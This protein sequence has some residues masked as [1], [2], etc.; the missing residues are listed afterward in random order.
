MKKYNPSPSGLP[1]LFVILYYL[2][3]IILAN[4]R[5]RTGGVLRLIVLKIIGFLLKILVW[6]LLILLLLV[7]VAL[8][9]PLHLHVKYEPEVTLRLRYFFLKFYIL[10]EK[11]PKKPPG[12]FRRALA[13]VGKFL[14]TVLSLIKAGI[15]ALFRWIGKGFRWVKAKLRR[16]PKKKKTVPKKEPEEKRLSFFGALKEQRGFFGA[17]E[18][19]ADAGKALGGAVGKIYR[20]I[21]ID[22]L[23]LHAAISGEDAADTAV[24]Y[25]R[26]CA[27][28]FPALSFLLGS[29]RGYDPASPRTKDIEIV[30]DFAGEGI[31]L[32][33]IGEFTLF[34]LL[35]VGNLLWAVIQFAVSQ[36]KI[37][38][39]IKKERSE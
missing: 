31:K 15:S 9:I 37:S 13:A 36:L 28:V 25:G 16:K 19:F 8:C 29:T 18:F 22:R 6:L 38:S 14:L 10:G 21:R 34:P 27:G 12:L 35:M 39:K 33:F 30:P 2:F 26:I 20:G 5:E 11:P 4:E 3:S 7:L 17:I 32:Y 23:A 1:Q 24:R